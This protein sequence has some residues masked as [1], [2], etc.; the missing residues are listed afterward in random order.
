MYD[1]GTRFN[2]INE[3]TWCT[4][5]MCHENDI[6]IYVPNT[7]KINTHS[8]M[9]VPIIFIVPKQ[10]ITGLLFVCIGY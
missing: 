7:E 1:N 4:A 8:I 3:T 5:K 2:V 6:K 10:V 9:K